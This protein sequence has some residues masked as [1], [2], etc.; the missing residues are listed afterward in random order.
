MATNQQVE[1]DD[2]AFRRELPKALDRIT[3][4][5][6][7]DLSRLGFMVQNAARV[8]CPV[9]TG[10]LRSSIQSTS[11]R[12]SR[13]PF[14]DVGTNVVYAPHV[15]Y[16]TQHMAAQPYMRPA[17]LDAADQWAQLARAHS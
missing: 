7:G 2:R 11:G 5:T 10:R 13:G 16:G 15:E 4:R 8:R 9:A 1:F 3:L 14:V 17:L 6:E 12:D